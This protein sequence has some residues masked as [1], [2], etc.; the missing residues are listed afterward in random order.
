VDGLER[1]GLEDEVG[2]RRLDVDGCGGEAKHG[3]RSARERASGQSTR[4]TRAPWERG[5][6]REEGARC[7]ACAYA[8]WGGRA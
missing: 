5:S 8:A 7:G 4:R 2:Q 1:D 6:G 3:K